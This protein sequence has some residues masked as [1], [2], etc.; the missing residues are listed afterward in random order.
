LESRFS[1]QQEIEVPELDAGFLSM[2]DMNEA[3]MSSKPRVFLLVESRL[4]REALAGIL[5]KQTDLTVLGVDHYTPD[6][7][8]QVAELEC[9]I[10]LVHDVTATVA[11]PNLIPEVL[12]RAPQ[13]KI[14]LFGMRN[15]PESFLQAV[16]AGVR[17]YL[18]DDASA[19]DIIAAVRRVAQGEA[20]CPSQLSLALFQFVSRAAEGGSL[21]L[22]LRVCEKLGLSR[23]QQQLA[24]F[25]AKGLTNK[26]IAASLHLSEFTVKNHVHRMMRQLNVESRY[27]A[28]QT[29]FESGYS[30]S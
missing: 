1:C 12:G 19:Q 16:R 17:G 8:K 2:R 9:E 5:R 20:V 4:L 14:I 27:E 23:R 29:I 11:S 25:L 26:E 24:S 28:V 30:V 21:M 18:L 10:L 15:D 22:N 6:A 3:G 7:Q 13:V